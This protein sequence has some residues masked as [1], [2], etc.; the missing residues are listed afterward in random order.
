MLVARTKGVIVK[1]MTIRAMF[2]AKEKFSL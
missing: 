1:K 2:L